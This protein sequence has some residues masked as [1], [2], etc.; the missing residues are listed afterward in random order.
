M[1]FGV[2]ADQ[3]RT[4]QVV[5]VAGHSPADNGQDD[6]TGK[7]T[8]H[9]QDDERRSPDNGRAESRN[10]GHH[11]H[12]CSPEDCSLK[13]GQIKGK[14]AES[15]LQNTNNQGG[16]HGCPG[17]RGKAV[18]QPFFIVVG[19]RQIVENFVEQHIAHGEKVKHHIEHDH[20]IKKGIDRHLGD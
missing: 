6:H 18:Q 9:S 1:H 16:L 10:Y 4:E 14:S 3:T 8:G 11:R 13:P 12:H 19:K 17:H 7:I 2:F 20:Y 5:Q 15:A